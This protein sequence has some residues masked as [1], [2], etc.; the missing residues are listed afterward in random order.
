M[1]QVILAI[2]VITAIISCVYVI[3]C[4]Q[5]CAT[6]EAM[7]LQTEGDYKAQIAQ[8]RKEAEMTAANVDSARAESER[9]VAEAKAD[10]ERN[11]AVAKQEMGTII[12]ETKAERDVL[13]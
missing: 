13:K 8:L 9:R 11:L 7:R 2:V 3:R 4:K 10:A 12:T 6:V 5:K 1:E